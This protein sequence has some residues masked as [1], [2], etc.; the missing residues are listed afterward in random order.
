MT[1][2]LRMDAADFRHAAGRYPTGVIVVTAVADGVDHA[3]TANSFTSVSLDP[4]LV[5]FCVGRTSR[6]HAVVRDSL[7]WGISILPEDALEQAKHFSTPGRNIEGEFDG[8]AVRRSDSGVLLL[9]D[10]LVVMECETEQVVAAGDHD[11]MIGR[12]TSMVEQREGDPLV[13]WSRTWRSLGPS[14]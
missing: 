5:L 2:K 9:E 4:L 10:A 14:I 12:V 11:I 7:H 8:I 6:F 3:M 1:G 13:Y